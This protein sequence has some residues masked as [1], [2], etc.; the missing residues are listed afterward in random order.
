MSDV[1][2][3]AV[4]TLMWGAPGVGKT[5]RAF[6]FAKRRNMPVIYLPLAERDPAEIAGASYIDRDAPKP[7]AR[8]APSE[9]WQAACDAPHVIILDELTAAVRLA[10]IAALRYADYSSGLHPETVVIATAN[11]P[12]YAAGAGDP[13]TP[14]DLS[15]WRHV[16]VSAESAVDWMLEQGGDVGRVAAYLTAHSTAALATSEAMAAATERQA[17]FATPRG[18]TRCAQSGLPVD[19]WGEIIGEAAVAGWIAWLNAGDLP[20]VEEI[21]SG[22]LNTIPRRGDAVLA[23]AA[24][25]AARCRAEADP[26]RVECM[27][28]WLAAASEKHAGVIA[29]IAEEVSSVHAVACV[30][31]VKDGRWNKLA[32][33]VTAK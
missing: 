5:A 3:P 1:F 31:A 4:P 23:T 18:W 14:P 16:Q 19:V 27:I 22:R 26:R 20:D 10:R 28:N 17:P 25:L 8:F 12:E 33:M 7:V 24:S 2:S 9:A 11:P 13:L 32:A 15:R 29:H 21:L 6:A 30:N